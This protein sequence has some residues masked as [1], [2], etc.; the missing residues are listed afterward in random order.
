MINGTM[1]RMMTFA[2][3]LSALVA[4][5]SLAPAGAGSGDVAE[6]VLRLP[7]TTDGPKSLDPIVGSTTYEN[8]CCSQIFDT[9]VQYK[10]LKRP[11]ELEPALLA[12]MPV[13]S[14]DGKVW[15][16][17]L[18]KGVRFQDDACFPGGKGREIVASDVF[19]SWKRAADPKYQF[20]SYWLLEDTIVGL[21]EFKEAQQ[22]SGSFD[23]DAPVEGF[24]LINDHEFELV[25]KRPVQQFMWKLAMFQLSIVPREA[26]EKYGDRFNR[27]PVGSGPFMLENESDWQ[28]GTSLVLKRNPNYRDEFYPSEAMPGDAEA[29]L[30]KAAG[31]KLPIADRIEIT[32][33]VE[34][35]PMWLKFEAGELDYTTVPETAY[36]EAFSRRS[37][38]LKRPYEQ[39]GI[40]AHKVPLIDFIF[41]GF[42]M[43]DPLLGGYTNEKR[44]LRKAIC[45]ALDW[46]EMNEA[47]YNGTALVYDGMIP[48]GL[49]GYPEDGHLPNAWRGPDLERA[50]QFLAEAGYPD[51]QG[52][53]VI[54]YYTSSGG[55]S[56]RMAALTA[57]QLAKVNIR[58][59]PRL[60]DFSTLM[61][62]VD[63]KKAPF[64]SF[65]W[66]SDYPDAENNLALFYGPNEAPKPNHF[67]YK[68]AEYDRLYEK[69]RT[70]PPGPE[71][72]AIYIQMRDMVLED[73]PYAGSMARIRHFLV[74]PWLLNFK[75]TETFY[76]WMKYLDVDDSKRPGGSS[77]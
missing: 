31:Q 39:R 52:L 76:T 74:N 57:R 27:H 69:I 48:H 22:Q 16:C 4:A 37:G 41:R 62:A 17:T 26:V 30:T 23:Y 63:N 28:I 59:N 1:R 8:R 5:P 50:R 14:E 75:P 54:D 36:E 55:T 35:Q 38:N 21:D 49:D 72:T 67:N 64:F 25:F 65:A 15:H 33:F 61:E 12:E 73:C 77:R 45:L 10:Y 24:R 68:N 42:N 13:I 70:M 7:M 32:F 53:P 29:G 60:V 9:L 20:K 71:R 58:I 51:G 40:T 47:Y 19:Y 44:A 43:E 34:S 2:A 46:D 3:V 6:K 18:K 11:F 56:E 66:G